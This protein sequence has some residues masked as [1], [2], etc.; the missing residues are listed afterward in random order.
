LDL[1]GNAILATD[2]DYAEVGG[3][4]AMI[5]VCVTGTAV[6][7][8]NFDILGSDRLIQ[9]EELKQSHARMVEISKFK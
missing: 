4:K 9:F 6:R 5:M 7:L 3:V 1:E 2:I 8:K